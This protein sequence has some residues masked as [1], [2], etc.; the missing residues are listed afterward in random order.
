MT[1]EVGSGACGPTLPASR[2]DPLLDHAPFPDRFV[3][4]DRRGFGHQFTAEV[5]ADGRSASVSGPR[6]TSAS[7]TWLPA[8]SRTPPVRNRPESDTSDVNAAY[9]IGDSVTTEYSVAGD[10]DLP[11]T[12]PGRHLFGHMRPLLAGDRHR[13]GLRGQRG[14]GDR[15]PGQPG[16]V[17]VDQAL[18]ALGWTDGSVPSGGITVP[19]RVCGACAAI[20]DIPTGIPALGLPVVGQP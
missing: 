17:S 3:G 20:T 13:R 9:E 4:G 12:R 1:G 10:R 2:A 19:I 5:G 15:R 8:L 18:T 14:V 7:A 6:G 11:S 16:P